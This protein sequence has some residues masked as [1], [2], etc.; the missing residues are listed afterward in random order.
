MDSPGIQ[1]TKADAER[2][3]AQTIV[4]FAAWLTAQPRELVRAGMDNNAIF[5]DLA[6][7]FAREI[8]VPLDPGEAWNGAIDFLANSAHPIADAERRA[9]LRENPE[10]GP[11]KLD[12]M[13][14]AFLDRLG[15]RDEDELAQLYATD[16][17]IF[18]VGGGE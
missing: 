14:P 1:L 11:P 6:E 9:E 7:S 3:T 16:R 12:E 5:V 2:V 13:S 15:V 17:A 18:E 4:R 8:G 10:A